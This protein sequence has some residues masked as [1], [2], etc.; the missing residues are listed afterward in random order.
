MIAAL[1]IGIGIAVAI[2]VMVLLF[3]PLFGDADGFGECVRFWLTPDL[4]S[5]FKGEYSEDWWAEMKLGIWLFLAGGCGF[6]AWY[7]VMQL[8]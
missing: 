8:M 2:G 1:A 4:L 6:A 5:L 3:K 7:G